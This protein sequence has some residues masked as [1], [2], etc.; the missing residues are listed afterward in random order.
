MER[1]IPIT[2]DRERHV[3]FDYL[4]LKTIQ[5]R[6][7]K[8]I[9]ELFTDLTRLDLDA[10]TVMLVEGLRHE[11][12]GLR[13]DHVDGW[14]NEAIATRRLDVRDLLQVLNDAIVASGFFGEDRRADSSSP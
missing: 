4:A 12:K 8:P 7:G 11:D 3:K 1:G 13:Q 5:R 10:M 6:F 2:L 9:G 14:I